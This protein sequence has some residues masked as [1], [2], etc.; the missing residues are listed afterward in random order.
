MM[1][2]DEFVH[3]KPN[4]KVVCQRNN[5]LLS[6]DGAPN[7]EISGVYAV[8]LYFICKNLTVGA[9]IEQLAW[10][11]K[12]NKSDVEKKYNDF[13]NLLKDYVNL[14]EVESSNSPIPITTMTTLLSHEK[15]I[16]AKQHDR[17]KVPS[18]ISLSITPFCYMNCIYC[19]ANAK[20]TENKVKALISLNR[21]RCL[22]DEAK[23]IGVESFELT[24]GDPFCVENIVEYLKV[25]VDSGMKWHVSTK[26][27]ISVKQARDLKNAGIDKL[28]VSMD[29]HKREIVNY[30][31]NRE[32]GFDLLIQT[33]HNLIEEGIHVRIKTVISSANI[34]D[35]PDFIEYLIGEGVKEVSFSWYGSLCGRSLQSLYPQQDDVVWL[36]AQMDRLQREKCIRIEYAKLGSEL[37]TFLDSPLSYKHYFRKK[38]SASKYRM[39]INWKGDV[40]FCEYMVN[41]K[42]LIVGNINDQSLK[43]LWL[44]PIMS[45]LLYPDLSHFEGTDCYNCQLFDQCYERRCFLRSKHR[46]GE[47]FEKDPW[48]LYGDEN[49]KEY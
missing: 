34:R 14:S 10:I 47:V 11:F 25:L 6:R 4:V 48:C 8:Y 3:M 41:E 18:I 28:Q 16:A 45:S 33:I 21:F 9:Q 26:A 15:E 32:N 27:Y 35:I 46:Y 44:S 36:N 5:V 49:Y 40:C 19:Y 38:C 39:V 20:I 23:C 2:N 43:E 22:V 7:V 30:L 17:K 29:S 1:M 13:L 24:G 42:A 12:C 37:K 31:T